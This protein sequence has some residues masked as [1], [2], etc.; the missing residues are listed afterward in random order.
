MVAVGI[1]T[2]V[3]ITSPRSIIVAYN[4]DIAKP[5]SRLETSNAHLALQYN[6]QVRLHV[7]VNYPSQQM[8]RVC[9]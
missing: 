8:A 4:V 5:E 1:G 6:T 9:K 2:S 3:A 7:T